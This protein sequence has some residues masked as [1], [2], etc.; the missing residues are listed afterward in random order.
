MKTKRVK[1]AV[2]TVLH[3]H[4]ERLELSDE[5]IV[6]LADEVVC[7]LAVFDRVE[8]EVSLEA[9][10]VVWGKRERSAL[11]QL[12]KQQLFDILEASLGVEVNGTFLNELYKELWRKF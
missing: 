1:I 8:K 11:G 9:T 4:W 10:T 6:S 3:L 12:S 5:D 2:Q 7:Y